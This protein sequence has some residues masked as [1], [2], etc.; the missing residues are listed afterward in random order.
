MLSEFAKS[1]KN[2]MDDAL[3]GQMELKYLDNILN[4]E[5]DEEE[6]QN[7]KPKTDSKVIEW[8]KF[9]YFNKD[10]DMKVKSTKKNL[11]CILL[12]V[13][14]FQDTVLVNRAFTLLTRF[15][16]QKVAIIKYASEVQLLQDQQEVAILHKVSGVLR[17]M[18]KDAEN[19]EFWIG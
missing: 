8:M 17:V 1:D 15:F 5:P 9:S 19:S 16:N 10:L 14:L 7:I 3:S 13:I 6:I 12:D 2:L 11:I 4:G 18:R